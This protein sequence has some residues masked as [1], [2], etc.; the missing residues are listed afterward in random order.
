MTIAVPSL[1]I[2]S[3]APDH[4][5]HLTTDINDALARL[6]AAVDDANAATAAAVTAEIAAAVTAGVATGVAPLKNYATSTYTAYAD[7]TA[8]IFV[9]DTIPHNTDGTQILSATITPTSVTSKIRVRG[10]GW[11]HI[12][13]DV[14]YAAYAVFSSQS[15]NAIQAGLF[16]GSNSVAIEQGF[17]FEVL[18]S[19]AT[20]SAVTYSVRVGPG[21][22]AIIRLNGDATRLF[23][24]TSSAHLV[25]EELPA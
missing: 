7:L 12:Y 20:T 19:P 3:E 10:S 18:H 23:G 13:T 4:T 11:G 2:G 5:Q 1:V 15:A 24:G 6:S 25:V 16:S 22:V 8:A 9:D 14:V 17:A 21:D